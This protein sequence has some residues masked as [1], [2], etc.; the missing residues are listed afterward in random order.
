MHLT[1]R[2]ESEDDAHAIVNSPILVQI[3]QLLGT[4][5]GNVRENADE[6]MIN[7]MRHKTNMPVILV[8]KTFEIIVSLLRDV[9][10]GVIHIATYVLASVAFWPHGAHAVIN[11]NTLPHLSELLESASKWV[12]VNA[13]DLVGNLALHESTLAAILATNPFERLVSLLRDADRFLPSR[14]SRFLSPSRTWDADSEIIQQATS[15]LAN[16]AVWRDGAKAVITANTLPHLLELLES[17][18][19]LVQMH[20][21][22]LVRNLACH[23]SSLAAILAA[24][25]FE[26]LVSLLR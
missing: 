6:L 7:L 20:A 12:R 1:R 21:C 15:A 18:S 9:N 14:V 13:C 19:Y 24:N 17:A 11:A 10:V 26:R 8:A 3:P 2:A 5:N 25:P 22:I 23:E 4:P 16:L